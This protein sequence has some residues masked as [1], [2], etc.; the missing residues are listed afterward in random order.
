MRI[1][2][3]TVSGKRERVISES[4]RFAERKKSKLKKMVSGLTFLTFLVIVVVAGVIVITRVRDKHKQSGV[5]SEDVSSVLRPSVDI[6][7]ESGIGIS[8]RVQE[9]VAHIEQDLKDYGLKMERA[10]I[11][12]N[13]SREVDIYIQGM[14]GYFKTSLDRVAGVSAEDIERM[15]RYLRDNGINETQYVDVRVEGKGYYKLV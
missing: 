1:I 15:I 2:G 4:E 13:Y 6:V 8:S 3:R 5:T 9:Y 11:P 12:A 14:G 10:V 7:D